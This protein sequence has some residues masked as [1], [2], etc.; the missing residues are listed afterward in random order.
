M[1]VYTS[2]P[3]TRTTSLSSSTSD[4][5]SSTSVGSTSQSVAAPPCG[6]QTS[7]GEP[8]GC[9]ADDLGFVP[10]GY[11]IG[12][13][14]SNAPMGMYPCPSGMDASQCE[15]FKITCGNGVCEPNESCST[16]LIDC[17]PP[18]QDICNSYL[19]RA[20][21]PLGGIDV[22]QVPVNETNG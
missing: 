15:Q 9:W 14:L 8:Q 7:S 11:I 2:P 6:N 13:H 18:G 10:A 1:Y 4:S 5:S 3:T 20:E 21:P 17:L 12:P 22:C 16:C 19:G